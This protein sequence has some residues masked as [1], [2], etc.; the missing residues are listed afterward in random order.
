M[1]S[2]C[3]QEPKGLRSRYVSNLPVYRPSNRG[4]DFAEAI[5]EDTREGRGS[6]GGVVLTFG[7]PQSVTGIENDCFSGFSGGH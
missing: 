1:M 3:L 5:L 7:D 4:S 6:E 2:A